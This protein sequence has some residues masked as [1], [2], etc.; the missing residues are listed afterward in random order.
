MQTK[1]INALEAARKLLAPWATSYETPES[2]R[3][4]VRVDTTTLLPAVTALGEARWG[5][6]AAIT[7]L[8]LG[9][10]AGKIEVLYH[11][12]SGPAVLTL[13]VLAERTA[14]RVPSICIPIPPAVVFERE[15]REMMGVEIVG[16]PDNE[17]LFLPDD[18]PEGVYPLRK[19]F[20]PVVSQTT[21]KTP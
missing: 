11:F 21:A 8:D 16:L 10:E 18:W 15:L 20:V 4:D 3:L 9:I 17:H 19:D 14:A 13:R 6:L 2:H 5:Y 7:G 1:V 12:C